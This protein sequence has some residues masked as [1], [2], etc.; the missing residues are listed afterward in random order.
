MFCVII[1]SQEAI[2]LY[3][4]DEFIQRIGTDSEKWE[5]GGHGN[6]YFDEN[7]L[8][9]S[10]AD[11]D[12]ALAPNI[13][14]AIRQRLD[15]KILGYTEVATPAFRKSVTD[16]FSRRFGWN[17]DG[18]LIYTVEGVMDGVRLAIEKLSEEGEGVII[19]QPVYPPFM[20]VV[21]SLN[22]KLVVN[23]LIKD[24]NNFYS[25]NFDELEKL[26]ADE[27]NKIFL[28]CSPHNPVGRVWT[29]EELSKMADLCHK[30]GVIL[31]S[32]E[33][34]CDLTRVGVVHHP[35]AKL[36][37]DYDII[38]CVSPSKTFNIAGLQIANMVFSSEKLKNKVAPSHGGQCANPLSIAALLG[39]YNESEDWLDQ[40]KVYI[41]G[42]LKF[43]KEWLDENLPKIVYRIPDGTYLAWLDV[44]AYQPDSE[45]FAFDCGK[46]GII[47]EQGDVFGDGGKGFIRFN[48]GTPRHVIKDGLERMKEVIQKY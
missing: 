41:D 46:G 13:D 8:S 48:V 33:I 3:N 11:M 45:K 14:K 9:F 15:K 22:R 40:V 2:M 1:L 5:S 37:P 34:H 26:L 18:K 35:V 42:N 24:E 30:Y 25:I 32:D 38:T 17:F 7:S 28:L 39:A 44:S 29:E 31:L 20:R 16:W 21:R 6:V 27:N 12:F 47:V 36:K 4:F 19:Q 10:I 43:L 23:H